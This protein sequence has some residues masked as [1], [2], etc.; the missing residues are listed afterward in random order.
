MSVPLLST[1]RAHTSRPRPTTAQ[2]HA[3]FKEQQSNRSA[4]GAPHSKRL[5]DQH[6]PGE[7]LHQRTAFPSDLQMR[8]DAS[9]GCG[10]LLQAGMQLHR[11][12]V[13]AV[14]TSAT[15]RHLSLCAIS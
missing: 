8:H 9:T 11:L 12:P 3:S 13:P 6:V 5:R 1:A 14:Y 10:A 2:S 15:C 7:R 4:T